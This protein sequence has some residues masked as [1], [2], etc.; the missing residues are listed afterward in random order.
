[1]LHIKKLLI[2]NIAI[3]IGL[4]SYGQCLSTNGLTTFYADNNG[5]AGQ[6]FDVVALVDVEICLM[7]VN[8]YAGTHQYQ[9]STKAGTHVGF[10]STPGAWTLIGGPIPITGNGVGVATPIPLPI[11]LT[12][13][14]GNTGSI[15]F[16]C[17]R[18]ASFGGNRYTNGIAVGNVLT[19]NAD[20]QILDGTGKAWNFGT[21]YRPRSFNGTLYYDRINVLPVELL[22]FNGENIKNENH[23]WWNTAS[24][25]NAESFIVQ[26]SKD[27][28][29]YENITTIQAA[30]NSNTIQNYNYIDESPNEG[31]NYYRL[32]QVDENGDK[33]YSKIIAVNKEGVQDFMINNLYPNPASD[34]LIIDLFSKSEDPLKI[35]IIDIT[36][37][38]VL[39]KY[40]TPKEGISKM[41]FDLS[42]L[43][44][45]FYSI[46]LY[47]DRKIMQNLQF[48]KQ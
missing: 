22:D 48:V 21:N 41:K 15:Y 45:G 24:E 23:L 40:I 3:L 16:T 32:K 33:D 35:C 39:E 7:D 43:N 9:I 30:G 28:S 42:S 4:A 29:Y 1:M 27:G 44:A 47:N 26:R 37:K 31:I 8:L 6:Q 12:I 34:D 38:P 36:G 25:I 13:L 46:R 10:E 19:A 5:Q 17:D 11:N 14:A 18:T 2:I 20:I